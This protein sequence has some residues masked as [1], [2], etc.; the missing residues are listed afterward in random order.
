MATQ[1][2]TGG[3]RVCSGIATQGSTGGG[4]FAVV[5]PHKSHSKVSFPSLRNTVLIVSLTAGLALSF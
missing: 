3:G 1:G 4:R 5:L 2:S